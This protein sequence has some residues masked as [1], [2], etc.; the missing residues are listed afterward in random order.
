M[1]I[2]IIIIIIIIIQTKYERCTTYNKNIISYKTNILGVPWHGL[3][4]FEIRALNRLFGP[5]RDEL[6]GEWRKL[7]N[8]EL[9][10]LYCSPNIMRKIKSRLMRWAG[11]WDFFFY[12]ECRMLSGRGLC[13]ELITRPE[14]SYQLWCVVVRDLET[15][16]IRRPW[17]APKTN[18]KLTNKCTSI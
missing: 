10:D 16:W 17:V 6:T 9:N 5:K 11:E 12:C 4:V 1:V 18:R 13:D 8:E 3:R 2:I 7:Y 14:E 15:S